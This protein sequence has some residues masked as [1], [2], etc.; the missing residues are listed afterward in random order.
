M[1]RDARASSTSAAGAYRVAN[2]RLKPT[3]NTMAR[4]LVSRLASSIA[5]ACLAC[6]ASSPH[7]S[8]RLNALASSL[9]VAAWDDDQQISARTLNSAV[10]T[11]HLTTQGDHISPD[12]GSIGAIPNHKNRTS[13]RLYP[14]AIL[15][16]R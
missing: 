16:A 14:V 4:P 5:S 1:S 15:R 3:P 12:S 8:L 2:N 9:V 6:S 11:A 10:P 13:S 7:S